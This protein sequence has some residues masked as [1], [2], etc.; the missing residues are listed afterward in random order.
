VENTLRLIRRFD[1]IHRKL[2]SLLFLSLAFLL[3]TTESAYGQSQL[4]SLSVYLPESGEVTGWE[5]N[6]SKEEYK[7]DDLYIYIN[8]GAEIYHEYG[9]QRVIVQDYKNEKEK[10]VS[11]E[12]YEMKSP[13]SAYG[14]Y[15]FKTEANGKPVEIGHEGRLE[16][17]YLNFW[18]GKFL[19]TIT[20]FEE[21][22]ETIRGLIQI[23]KTVEKKLFREK[24]EKPAITRLLP[25]DR[26]DPSGIK[27][28]KGHLGIFNSYPFSTKNIFNLK[29]GIKGHL[30]DNID[31][32]IIKYDSPEQ[33]LLQF[34]QAKNSLKEEPRY[35][36]F[37]TT[38]KTF[39]LF[40]DKNKML[41]FEPRNNYILIV[42]GAKNDKRAREI[43]QLTNVHD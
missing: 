39:S 27:Y 38:T 11:L 32:Y 5:K 29:E 33:C 2:P 12:L 7:G 1:M 4:Q 43:I 14:I 6:F 31:V 3:N 42:L 22:E 9:F 10:S 21:D 16:G 20:G 15:T 35:K 17:Y 8:G 18:K 24:G 37:A 41:Y 34:N 28:F 19:V 23:A 30:K 25:E 13:E 26:F 40:D 36:N